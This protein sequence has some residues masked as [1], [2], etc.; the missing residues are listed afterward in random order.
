MKQSEVYEGRGRAG[1]SEEEWP[2]KQFRG[3]GNQSVIG[4][5]LSM[6]VGNG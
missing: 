4:R 2:L 6:K 1:V 3:V 5:L